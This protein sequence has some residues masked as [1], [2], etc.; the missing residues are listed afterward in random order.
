MTVG[1]RR[2]H[3]RPRGQVIFIFAVALVALLAMTGLIIDGGHA[4]S[5]QRHVQNAADAAARAGALVL[6]RRAGEEGLDPS[7]PP[8][9]PLV[10]W[11]EQV[12]NEVYLSAAQNGVTV[13]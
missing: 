7:R 12:R 13:A 11:G 6:G 1:T 4:W 3:D 2:S 8:P 5:Q 9:P 10:P